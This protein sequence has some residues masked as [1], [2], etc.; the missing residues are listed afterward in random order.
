MAG[1]AFRERQFEPDEVRRIVRRATELAAKDP[2]T[3]TTAR[4]LTQEELEKLVETLGI[5]ASAVRRA[6]DDPANRSVA[7]DPVA[8]IVYEETFDGEI[9]VDR[10]EEIAEQLRKIMGMEGGLE[11]IGHSL[12]WRS[13]RVR[14]QG[15]DVTVSVRSRDGATKV[16]VEENMKG[17]RAGFLVVGWVSFF[18]MSI[19]AAL[20][21]GK[22][23]AS[24]PIAVMLGIL[25]LVTAIFVPSRLTARLERRRRRDLEPKMTRISE[26]VRRVAVASPEKP[27]RTRIAAGADEAEEAEEAGDDETELDDPQAGGRRARR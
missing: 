17:V 26:I 21:L 18:P 13:A 24:V 10:H 14:G 4:S 22:L 27:A 7:E 12:T 9:P 3:A 1:G 6:I 23:T 5:P 19:F 2:A 15:R 16:V 20:A 11:V 25:A 8:A